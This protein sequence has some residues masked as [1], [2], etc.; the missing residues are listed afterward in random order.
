MATR[1]WPPEHAASDVEEDTELRAG[2]PNGPSS[3][4]HLWVG[5][6]LYGVLALTAYLPAWPGRASSVPWCACD[7][8][9]QSIWFLDWTPFAILHGHNVLVSNWLDVPGGFNL[10]Q[11]VSMPLLGL[12]AAP[13]TLALGPVASFNFL[14]WLAL[15]ASAS[16]CYLTLLHWTRWKPAAFV[17]GLVYAFSSYMAGQAL[18]HLNLIFVPIPPLLILVLNELVIEQRKS[19]RRW[20]IA[21]G[22]LAAAQFLISPE[23]LVDSALLAVTGLVLVTVT[24]RTEVVRRAR[25]ALGGMAWALAVSLPFAVYPIAVFVAGPERYTGSPWDGATYAED[26]LGTI[27]PSLNQRIT[28]TGLASFGDRLLPDLAENGAYLGIPMVIILVVLAV[29]YRHVGIMWFSAAMATVAW[30][31]SL[32]P[33]LS[34]DTNQ[35]AI[36]LPF[37]VLVHLPILDSLLAGRFTLFLDL[38]C[39]FVLAVGIDRLRSDMLRSGRVPKLRAAVAVMV[40]AVVALVPVIPRWPYPVV[41]VDSTTPSFFETGDVK[42]I[43]AGSVVL[44]YPYPVYPFN[45]AMLWQAESSMRFRILGGYVLIP[46]PGG[47]A[48]N[49]PAPVLPTSVPATLIADFNGLAIVGPAATPEDVRSLLHRYGVQTVIVGPGGVDPDAAIALFTEALGPSKIVGGARIWPDLHCTGPTG[50]C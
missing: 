20:G 36:R 3:R 2:D 26:L 44:T 15:T 45:Q 40:V 47:K 38:F 35:T 39:G 48:T 18:G 30:L 42:E 1:G 43:P 33:H 6:V 14:L 25:H 49:A 13:L 46:G 27:I 4:R 8:T 7:D 5:I 17:G 16:A 10:A 50:G 37:D 23:I 11:N 32:G 12:L 29:R 21:L 34:V 41:P 28:T 31:L 24:H 19:A 22:L 9:A